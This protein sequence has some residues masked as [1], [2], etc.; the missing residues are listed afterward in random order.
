MS[1]V[2]DRLNCE[3]E[4]FIDENVQQ[5]VSRIFEMSTM[6]YSIILTR[7]SQGLVPAKRET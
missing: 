3:V 4:V 5:V 1:V 2:G 7:Q 6:S